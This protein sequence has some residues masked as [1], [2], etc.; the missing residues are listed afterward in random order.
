MVKVTLNPPSKMDGSCR[1]GLAT[2]ATVQNGRSSKMD[3]ASKMDEHLKDK[4]SE[5]NDRFPARDV[6]LPNDERRH[7][8]RTCNHLASRR[9]EYGD[10][11]FGELVPMALY[12]T[13]RDIE[14]LGSHNVKRLAENATE[15]YKAKNGDFV[16][17]L[18]KYCKSLD[19]SQK[20]AAL[21]GSTL[22]LG[23]V[24]Y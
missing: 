24:K 10:I 22:A 11:P 20:A 23:F 13:V 16:K 7:P 8:E 3:E 19:S 15:R 9:N 18:F 6:N 21:F 5:M 12:A 1:R 14:L 2:L 4:A 17:A